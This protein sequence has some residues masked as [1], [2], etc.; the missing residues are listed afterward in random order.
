MILDLKFGF[1]VRFHRLK[2]H[3]ADPSKI[4]SFKV[5]RILLGLKLSELSKLPVPGSL[6]AWLPGSLMALWLPGG[7]GPR[8][9]G[10]A[11]V[12]GSGGSRLRRPECTGLE[13]Q[14][15]LEPPPHAWTH[16]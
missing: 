14:A 9:A 3:A 10:D 4:L 15:V 16:A 12:G 8:E 5:L 1:Y 6:A 7:L 2:P 11:P 13:P